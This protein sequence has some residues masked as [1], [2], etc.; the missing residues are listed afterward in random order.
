[1]LMNS[2]QHLLIPAGSRDGMQQTL[3]ENRGKKIH[4][5]ADKSVQKELKLKI[6][7]K[8]AAEFPFLPHHPIIYQLLEDEG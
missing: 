5:R 3:T 8:S 7:C 4:I 2:L 6:R 1:M